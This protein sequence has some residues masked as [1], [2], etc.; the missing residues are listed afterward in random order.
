VGEP[1]PEGLVA[2]VAAA[3]DAPTPGDLW[4]LRGDLLERGIVRDAPLMAVVAE[5]H[6]FLDRLAG[7]HRGEVLIA[8]SWPGGVLWPAAGRRV[9]CN[10][11]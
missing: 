3:L 4:R 11:R 2:S 5:C 8:V 10:G 1:S 7:G 6:R 9:S